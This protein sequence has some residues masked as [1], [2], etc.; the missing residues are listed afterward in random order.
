MSFFLGDNILTSLSVG[1]ECQ[2]LDSNNVFVSEMSGAGNGKD[3][4]Q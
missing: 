2:L 1:R 4:N 3:N